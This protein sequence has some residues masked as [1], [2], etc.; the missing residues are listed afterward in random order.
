METGFQGP[1]ELVS[2]LSARLSTKLYWIWGIGIVCLVLIAALAALV[3]FADLARFP[4]M[5]AIDSRTIGVM[6][7][8]FGGILLIAIPVGW[9][10][11]QYVKMAR[12][13]FQTFHDRQD[14]E[15]LNTAIS[16]QHRMFRLMNIIFAVLFVVAVVGMIIAFAFLSRMMMQL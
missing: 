15:S 3:V 13:G 2:N 4:G 6:R 11:L 9:I 12:D 10:L 14:P 8:M 16:A 1:N 7:I 5:S